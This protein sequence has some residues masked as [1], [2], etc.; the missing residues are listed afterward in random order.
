MID[1]ALIDE[2]K[3]INYLEDLCITVASEPKTRR[4]GRS[5]QNALR[6]M[7]STM[8]YLVYAAICV[9]VSLV[10]LAPIDTAKFDVYSL[11]MTRSQ[12]LYFYN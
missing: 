8:R 7:R 6:Y 1:S 11:Q 9:E 12:F 4:T 3:L 5:N 2:E 10:G